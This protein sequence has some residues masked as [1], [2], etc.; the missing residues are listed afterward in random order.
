MA[1]IVQ[2]IQ[3]TFQGGDK[4]VDPQHRK[5]DAKLNPAAQHYSGDGQ[6]KEGG[7]DNE[8]VVDKIKDKISSGEKE[9]NEKNH[10]EGVKHNKAEAQRHAADLQH[11]EGGAQNDTI[12][13]KIKDKFSGSEKEIKH[14]NHGGA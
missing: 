2:K 1:G 6:H 12:V 9:K 11:K 3:E 7:V 4:N 8:S 5:D 14:K 10:K 13:D